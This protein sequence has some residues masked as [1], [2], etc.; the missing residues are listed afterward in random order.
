MPMATHSAARY[1]PGALSLAVMVS[2]FPSS[3][4]RRLLEVL[5]ECV[6][7][8]RRQGLLVVLGHDP[9]VVALGDLGIGLDDRALD[10]A[11]V[12]ALQPGVQVGPGAAARAGVGERVAGA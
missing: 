9:R 10:E 4:T 7:L 11:G 8:L 12:A 1:H 5:H 6:Q 2:S 3:S